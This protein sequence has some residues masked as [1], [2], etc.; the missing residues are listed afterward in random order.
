[1]FMCAGADVCTGSQRSTLGVA[2]HVPSSMLVRL[3]LVGLG[4]TDSARFLGQ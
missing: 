1:M 2:R 3:S 4:F